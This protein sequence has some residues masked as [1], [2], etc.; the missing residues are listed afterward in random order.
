MLAETLM[1]Q[2]FFGESRGVGLLRAFHAEYAGLFASTRLEQALRTQIADESRHAR[3]YAVMLARRGGA[4]LG[5]AGVDVGWQTIV[6]HIAAAHSFSTTLI[7]MYGLMEPFNLLA[8]QM[9]LPLLDGADLG[10]VEQ[11]AVEEARHIGMF[12]LYAELV[13]RRALRVDE[14]E[15]MAMIRVFLEALRGGIALPSGERVS[16]PRNEWREFMRHVGQLRER[17]QAWGRAA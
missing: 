17:I 3:S 1:R 16:L 15:S 7:G 5:R 8:M 14:A 13:E 4:P 12:D 10:E 9:L 11:I 2:A 6:G